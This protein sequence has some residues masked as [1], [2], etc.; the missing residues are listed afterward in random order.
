[1]KE[2]IK[3]RLSPLSQIK[4]MTVRARTTERERE[5]ERVGVRKR[6]ENRDRDRQRNRERNTETF[7][8]RSLMTNRQGSEKFFSKFEVACALLG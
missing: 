6:R 1:M 7:P 4:R 3:E 2:S 5:R 8:P